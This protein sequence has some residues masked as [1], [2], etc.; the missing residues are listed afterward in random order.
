M[1]PT[2]AGDSVTYPSEPGRKQKVNSNWAIGENLIY[3]VIYQSVSKV[4]VKHNFPYTHSSVNNLFVNGFFLHY[5][6]LGV[7]SICY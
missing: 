6:D 7:P 5:P 2:F 1:Y 3:I 4:K